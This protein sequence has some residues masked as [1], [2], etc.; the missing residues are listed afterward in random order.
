VKPEPADLK[1]VLFYTPDEVAALFRQ[2]CEQ[3]AKDGEKKKARRWVYRNA[4][5]CG[6]LAPYVRKFS[7]KL[8]LFDRAGIDALIG[9]SDEA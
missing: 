9:R 5:P 4:S 3:P 8:L 2:V 6:F 1:P 7:G